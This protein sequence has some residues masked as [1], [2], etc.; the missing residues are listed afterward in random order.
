MTD[1]REENPVHGQEAAQPGRT[2]ETVIHAVARVAGSAIGGIVSTA[3]NLVPGSNSAEHQAADAKPKPI[4]RASSVSSA[5]SGDKRFED[6]LFTKKRKKASH[7][8]V[9]KRTHANG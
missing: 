1:A 8:R 2:D 4:R 3:A 7:R 9:L 5:R 6:R